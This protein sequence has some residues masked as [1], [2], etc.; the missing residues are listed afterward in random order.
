MLACVSTIR[1]DRRENS[2]IGVFAAALHRPIEWRRATLG[3]AVILLNL[4]DAFGTL[5]NVDR[6]AE[7]LN[8]LMAVLLG[9]GSGQFVVLKHLLASIGVLGILVYPGTR[10]ARI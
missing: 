5:A 2:S 8:P 10:A 6:G 4:V 7:E 9:W 1:F 3:L